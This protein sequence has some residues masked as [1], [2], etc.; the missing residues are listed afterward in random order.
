MPDTVIKVEN[1]SKQY[2]IGAR[3]QGY[4]TFREAI[5]DTAKAPFRLVNTLLSAPS[6]LLSSVDE[7]ICPHI[8]TY[9]KHSPAFT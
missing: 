8:M 5:V 1:L 4:K 3:Q 6:S 7:T 9:K 2:R